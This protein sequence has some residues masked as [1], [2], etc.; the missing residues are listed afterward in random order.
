MLIQVTIAADGMEATAEITRDSDEETIDLQALERAT[1]E[2]GVSHGIDRAAG[3]EL[4]G[5]ANTSPVGKRVR[6]CVAHGSPPIDG[7]DGQLQVVVESSQQEVGTET[8]GGTIDF[9]DRGAHTPIEQDQLLALL[10]PPTT[11]TAGRDVRGKQIP[12]R[13]GRKA[14]F[15]PGQHTKL[16]AGGS[17]LRAARPGDLNISTNRISV[18]DVIRVPG[19]LDFRVGSIECEGS[20]QVEKDVLPGFTIRAGSDVRIGGSV[21]ASIVMARGAVQIHSGAV[22]GSRIYSEGTISVGHLNEAHVEC[23]GDVTIRKVCAQST[24]VAGGAILAGSARAIGGK[25][26]ARERVELG[27]A[28]Q[29]AGGLTVLAAGEDRLE[30][31][32][33]ARLGADHKKPSPSPK[34]K[35]SHELMASQLLAKQQAIEAE[36]AKKMVEM[37]ST[38]EPPGPAA[39]VRVNQRIHEGVRVQLGAAQLDIKETRAGGTF[40]LSQESNEI[41]ELSTMGKS[42]SK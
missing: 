20:V 25:A 28:G 29:P 39:Q 32:L 5:S 16:A 14:T 24:V 12:A 40:L 41:V 10:V 34:E 35:R 15:P 17:E 38:A 1:G 7:S 22:R 26:V 3:E 18:E 13:P 11:G 37:M 2:A 19:D 31:V 6:G 21:D 30:E 4:L 36:M 33:R 42:G 23:I 9:R 27:V 8:N